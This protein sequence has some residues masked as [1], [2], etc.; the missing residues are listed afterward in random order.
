MNRKTRSGK[1]DVDDERDAREARGHGDLIALAL[2]VR[3]LLQPATAHLGT[4]GH[5]WTEHLRSKADLRYLQNTKVHVSAHFTLGAAA[6][7]TVTEP[8]P[9]G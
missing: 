8:C 7:L 1:G 2:V 9:S 4:P 5:L 6:D 3:S